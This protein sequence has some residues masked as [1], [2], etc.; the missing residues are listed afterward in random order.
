MHHNI[1]LFN[2]FACSDNCQ[3]Q[4]RFVEK[5]HG[6]GSFVR[7][8]RLYIVILLTSINQVA[9]INQVP[10]MYKIKSISI[11]SCSMD[12]V[13][14]RIFGH[15]HHPSRTVKA[16]QA[17]RLQY[18]RWDLGHWLRCTELVCLQ[19]L[20]PLICFSKY[21]CAGLSIT[22]VCISVGCESPY[23]ISRWSRDCAS[24]SVPGLCEQPHQSFHAL[25]CAEY[26]V[27]LPSY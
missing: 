21:L 13:T 14:P 5:T 2:L 23:T 8:D 17:C 26:K 9:V 7:Q 12:C 25:Q 4:G 3:L 16:P 20:E 6:I 22:G 11:P 15:D 10:P 19:R 27:P 24:V 1:D 18:Q